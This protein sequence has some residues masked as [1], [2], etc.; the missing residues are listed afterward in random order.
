MKMKRI[1]AMMA[2]ATVLNSGVGVHAFTQN[3]STGTQEEQQ[4]D[5]DANANNLQPAE[6]EIEINGTFKRTITNFPDADKDG[7]YLNVSMPIALD[8]VY[9]FD[10]GLIS[11]HGTIINGSVKAEGITNKQPVITE[12]PINMEFVGLD[13][14]TSN[15]HS[16]LIKFVTTVDPTNDQEVQVPIRLKTTSKS[17]ASKSYSLEDIENGNTQAVTIAGGEKMQLEYELTPGESVANEQLLTQDTTTTKHALTLRF[18][19]K[20]K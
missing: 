6:G 8:F 15:G 14:D 9:D 4:Y 11:G 17:G 20:G 13:V 18:E 12:Q 5:A 2:L 7:H 16:D 19:Y 1:A 3:G 10:K